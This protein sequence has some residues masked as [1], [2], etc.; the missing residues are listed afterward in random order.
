MAFRRMFTAAVSKGASEMHS[1]GGGLKPDCSYSLNQPGAHLGTRDASFS[2][3]KPHD[4]TSPLFSKR[5][6]PLSAIFLSKYR[7]YILSFSTFDV[8][9][10]QG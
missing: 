8:Q 5:L 1:R 6:R 3:N 4:Y 10:V 7:R 2:R 9:N